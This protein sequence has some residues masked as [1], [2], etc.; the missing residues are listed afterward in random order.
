MGAGLPSHCQVFGASP[1]LRHLFEAALDNP[2]DIRSKKRDFHVLGLLVDEIGSMPRLPLNAP[3][4]AEPRL[5]RACQQ[6]LDSPSQAISIEEMAD[7]AS[8]SR[9]TFTRQFLSHTGM[10]FVAWRQQICLLEA[11]SQLA[12]GVPVTEVALGLGF[13][14]PS[15]FTTSFRKVLGESPARYLRKSIGTALF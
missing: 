9:R 8:M 13:S 10:T 5:L 14:S 3:L 11:L 7:W 6:L 12:N 2:A 15:A 1:L 4:P